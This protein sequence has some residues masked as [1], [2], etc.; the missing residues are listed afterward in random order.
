[1]NNVFFAV[2]LF[3]IIYTGLGQE[4]TR[5]QKSDKFSHTVGSFTDPRDGKTYK[6][7]T[8]TRIKHGVPITR[9]WYAENVQY[10][11]EGSYCYDDTKEYCNKYGRL[12]NYEQANK[13]CPEGWH[14]PTIAEWKYLFDFF[15]GW[16]HSG[17]FLHEDKASD[18]EML[19]GGF[20]EPG[21]FFRQLGVSGNWWDNEL[22]DSNTAG[23]ITLKK[24]DD[25]IYHSNIGDRHMLSCRCV[26]YHN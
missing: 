22:K 15:G 6:T 24:D 16:N 18:M 5:E 20:G 2:L 8:F 25:N 17:Q 13:A 7:V 10:E 19:Y 23:I 12:Y 9:T 3:G 21:H 1:M 14:V 11:V 26:Q 4:K